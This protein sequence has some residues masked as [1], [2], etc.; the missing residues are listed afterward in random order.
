LSPLTCV[1]DNANLSILGPVAP[2]QLITIYGNGIGPADPV[3]GVT[4][5]ATTVPTAAGGVTVTFDGRPA[6]ILY[7]SSTQINVQAPFEI[8]QNPYTTAEKIV[9]QVSWNG[10]VLATQA[11]AVTPR[12]PGL[13]VGS[14]VASLVCGDTRTAN[15]IV[16]AVALNQDGSVN[17]CENPA[18]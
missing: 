14:I 18:P 6:P 13:F 12:N 4:P 7:A 3:S 9:M 2:G 11:F 15:Y 17:T 16:I 8:E 10:S 1:T 5:G